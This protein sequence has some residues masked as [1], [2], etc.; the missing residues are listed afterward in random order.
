MILEDKP[1]IQGIDMN[2]NL[3]C[4]SRGRETSL[5]FNAACPVL[6]FRTPD[7]HFTFLACNFSYWLSRVKLSLKDQILG[8]EMVGFVSYTNE[9]LIPLPIL[10]FKDSV[11]SATLVT[12]RQFVTSIQMSTPLRMVPAS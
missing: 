9:T 6:R 5:N 2:E 1:G 8:S 4:D 10:H 3:N 11:L 12:A 7:F